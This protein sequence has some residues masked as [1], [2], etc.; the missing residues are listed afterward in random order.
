MVFFVA[1]SVSPHC[2]ES[3]RVTELVDEV[4]IIQMWLRVTAHLLRQLVNESESVIL[5]DVRGNLHG[6]VENLVLGA[7]WRMTQSIDSLVRSETHGIVNLFQVNF[8]DDFLRLIRSIP[9]GLVI[10]RGLH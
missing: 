2:L 5:V 7:V 8:V 10:Q 4:L 3:F 9:R 1:R 6:R